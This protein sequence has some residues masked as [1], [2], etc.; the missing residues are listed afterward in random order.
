MVLKRK[1]EDSDEQEVVVVKQ[2]K[3]VSWSNKLS[4]ASDSGP[5]TIYSSVSFDTSG[6]FH[7]VDVDDVSNFLT[8]FICL[9]KLLI[10]SSC[11]VLS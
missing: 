9:S 8:C 10:I 11:L 3:K 2:R 1:Y 5:S 4:I 6:S 7:E